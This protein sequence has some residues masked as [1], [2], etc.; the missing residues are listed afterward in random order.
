MGSWSKMTYHSEYSSRRALKTLTDSE[1]TARSQKLK[2]ATENLSG[3][4][5]LQIN[6]GSVLAKLLT[7]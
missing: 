5:D 2:K 4:I 3:R 6:A 1:L 7:L